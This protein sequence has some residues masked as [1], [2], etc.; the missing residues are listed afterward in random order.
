MTEKN[1][2][3]VENDKG[4]SATVPPPEHDT[5]TG[6]GMPAAVETTREDL[7]TPRKPVTVKV[8]SPFWTTSFT[9][10]GEDGDTLVVDR[11]GTLVPRANLQALLDAA[12][13][14]GVLLS[15]EVSD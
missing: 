10:P 4:E 11:N 7:D 1:P 8:V 6:E 12:A 13:R 14:Q 5:A 2:T 9:M 3:P 15:T